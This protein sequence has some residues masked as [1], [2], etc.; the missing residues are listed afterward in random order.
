[1]KLLLQVVLSALLRASIRAHGVSFDNGAYT[2][3]NPG[4]ILDYRTAIWLDLDSMTDDCTTC[5]NDDPMIAQT[6]CK[7][8]VLDIFQNG[9]NSYIKACGSSNLP[10][11]PDDPSE[12]PKRTISDMASDLISSCLVDVEP[13]PYESMNEVVSACNFASCNPSYWPVSSDGSLNSLML[14][15]VEEIPSPPDPSLPGIK[16]LAGIIIGQWAF[17]ESTKAITECLVQGKIND[18]S[19]SSTEPGVLTLDSAVAYIVGNTDAQMGAPTPSPTMLPTIST[20]A[21]RQLDTD[22]LPRATSTIF[23][24]IEDSCDDFACN[25]VTEQTEILQWYSMIQASLKAADCSAT[26]ASPPVYEPSATQELQVLFNNVQQ[27]I[28]AM[29]VRRLVQVLYAVEGG[30]N[31]EQMQEIAYVFLLSLGRAMGGCNSYLSDVILDNAAEFKAL[32]EPVDDFFESYAKPR[33]LDPVYAG[34]RCLNIQ[35]CNE[36]VTTFSPSE[37]GP[38]SCDYFGAGEAAAFQTLR[39]YT[40][41]TDVREHSYIGMDNAN[42]KFCMKNADNKGGPDF[43]DAAKMYRFGDYS[44][45][46]ATNYRSIRRFMVGSSQTQLNPNFNDAAYWFSTFNLPEA[47]LSENLKQTIMP[48]GVSSNFYGNELVQQ[49][50]N[51]ETAFLLPLEASSRYEMSFKLMNF[52]GTNMYVMREMWDVLYDCKAGVDDNPLSTKGVKAIDEAAVF[53]MGNYLEDIYTAFDATTNKID[54]DGFEYAGQTTPAANG[55]LWCSN[56]DK[57]VP[58]EG[59]NKTA[60]FNPSNGNRCSNSDDEVSTLVSLLT[61]V[62]TYMAERRGDRNETCQDFLEPRLNDLQRIINIPM[63]MGTLYYLYL[64]DP[65]VTNPGSSESDSQEYGAE[66]FA[67]MAPLLPSLQS[68]DPV[69][70]TKLQKSLRYSYAQDDDGDVKIVDTFELE[71]FSGDY[72]PMGY[73]DAYEILYGMLPCLGLSCAD[74]G[75]NVVCGGDVCPKCEDIIPLG[76]AFPTPLQDEDGG[77]ILGQY[78]EPDTNVNEHAQISQDIEDIVTEVKAGD[79]DEAI[80]IYRNGRN[81]QKSDT[82]RSLFAMASKIPKMAEPTFRAQQVANEESWANVRILELFVYCSTQQETQEQKDACA[83][84]IGIALIFNVVL[85]YVSHEQIDCLHDCNSGE[86]N[87][88]ADSKLACNEAAAFY[89]GYSQ[90]FDKQGDAGWSQYAMMEDLSREFFD[91]PLMDSG[92]AGANLYAQDLFVKSQAALQEEP[93]NCDLIADYTWLLDGLMLSNAV[94]GFWYFYVDYAKNS[95]GSAYEFEQIQTFALIIYPAIYMCSKNQAED[96]KKHAMTFEPLN[97]PTQASIDTIFGIIQDNYLCMGMSNCAMIG[98]KL[99]NPLTE[100][101]VGVQGYEVVLPVCQSQPNPTTCYLG[102]DDNQGK[103]FDSV[104]RYAGPNCEVT[105]EMMDIEYEFSHNVFAHEN[106]DGDIRAIDVFMDAGELLEAQYIYQSGRN[107]FKT[108]CYNADSPQP[109]EGCTTSMRTVQGFATKTGQTMNFTWQ[110]AAEDFYT[111]QCTRGLPGIDCGAR[112]FDPAKYADFFITEA[113]EGSEWTALGLGAAVPEIVTKVAQATTQNYAMREFTLAVTR[114][115][116]FED[117]EA[118]DSYPMYSWDEGVAFVT[119]RM[120][121]YGSDNEEKRLNGAL[122]M[123]TATKREANFEPDSPTSQYIAESVNGGAMTLQEGNPPTKTAQRCSE[124]Q[125][126]VA[127]MQ[128]KFIVPNLQGIEK[129]AYNYKENGEGAKE[130]GELFAFSVLAVPQIYACNQ[131]AGQFVWDNVWILA[132]EIMKDGYKAVYGAIESQFDCL[133]ISCADMGNGPGDAPP[134]G[135][136]S[137]K[138]AYEGDMGN[139]AGSLSVS[140]GLSVAVVVA[141][142]FAI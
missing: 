139:S 81:S 125:A 47:P 131:D 62:Q 43:Y 54:T 104:T 27:N 23:T 78:F 70:A 20:I 87:A 24:E 82:L 107:S 112:D 1:M 22:D 59:S 142:F 138:K 38:F 116:D 33:L 5:Q 114:Y 121:R 35:N 74:I 85:P 16:S 32:S 102:S 68:C 39:G 122:L 77:K 50:L 76:N 26:I 109:K 13:E 6:C 91:D 48:D 95:E 31:F 18:M 66:A 119:G 113:L 51:Q 34:L 93:R 42:V 64:G 17:A 128:Q 137:Y 41:Q 140:L 105:P 96:F 115:C 15:L 101:S 57:Y 2:A 67:F 133:G 134:C 73:T 80:D 84:L 126:L 92:A 123:N 72:W 117:G 124:L 83:D 49:S 65:E 45:K 79:I 8:A 63:V 60:R 30:E 118:T 108:Q 86:P 61:E 89:I 71:E 7:A 10:A 9:R 90:A 94:K 58:L 136:P 11:C 110:N 21:R 100:T 103:A 99:V 75:N 127:E 25:G 120:N 14:E 37:G 19:I 129:Y 111:D 52:L 106:I 135:D 28:H 69:G 12:L 56:V 4:H 55:N 40:T 98:P 97:P 53:A 44:R 130:A 29:E 141:W 88:N 132:D 3:T 46:S 36:D